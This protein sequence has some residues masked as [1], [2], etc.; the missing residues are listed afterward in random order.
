MVN[1]WS[2][3][4]HVYCH[5]YLHPEISSIGRWVYEDYRVYNPYSGVTS[6]SQKA[7]ALSSR[8]ERVTIDHTVL[9]LYYLQCYY[10]LKLTRGQ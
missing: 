6:I 10:L 9:A 8:M 2:A 7:S 1:K 3:P 5:K 4:F